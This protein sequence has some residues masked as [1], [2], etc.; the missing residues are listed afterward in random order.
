M[1][2]KV[3]QRLGIA[4]VIGCVSVVGIGLSFSLLLMNF[5]LEAR[6]VSGLIIGLI[7]A[8]GGLATIVV[9]PVV[10]RKSYSPH[11]LQ[12]VPHL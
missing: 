12:I 9:S 3:R 1:R 5:V 2:T 10:P 6:D 8:L 4:A 11:L 7:T